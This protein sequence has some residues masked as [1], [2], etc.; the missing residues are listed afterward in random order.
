MIYTLSELS[1]AA[2]R[3]GAGDGDP[4]GHGP[5]APAAIERE[6]ERERERECVCVREKTLCAASES[7][8]VCVTAKG[9]A[10][11]L[12][13]A[14]DGDPGGG[15]SGGFRALLDALGKAL[16]FGTKQLTARARRH[17]QVF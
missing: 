10:A 16:A 1:L 17:R 6:R 8:Q 4:G 5:A 7:A 14:G 9:G 15:V 2:G 12:G 11:G 13:R 3:G